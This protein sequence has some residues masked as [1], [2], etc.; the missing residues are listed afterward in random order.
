MSKKKRKEKIDAIYF[1]V[2]GHTNEGHISI[3]RR[4]LMSLQNAIPKTLTHTKE[5]YYIKLL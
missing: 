4:T 3:K 2:S 5:E 1:E